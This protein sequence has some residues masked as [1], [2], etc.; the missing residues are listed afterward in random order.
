MAVKQQT[1]RIS[2]VHVCHVLRISPDLRAEQ[3]ILQNKKL[4]KE[5]IYNTTHGD[6]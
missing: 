4:H 2:T 1:K 6:V 5:K 3:A